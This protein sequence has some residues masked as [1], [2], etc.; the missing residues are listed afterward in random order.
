MRGRY[1]L[2]LTRRM[3]TFG[4][5]PGRLLF[6]CN[7]CAS[8][9]MEDIKRIALET[10]TC[11]SCLSSLRMRA[12]VHL[13]ST[14]LF[15][16]SLVLRDFPVRRDIR[17]MGLSDWKKYASPLSKKLNYT[18]T[19]YHKQPK[20]DITDIEPAL[21]G[22]L[23]F[24]IASDVFEHVAPPVATSFCN[25]YR[26][27]KPGGVFVFTAPYTLEPDTVEHFADLHR[28]K[29]TSGRTPRLINTTRTGQ[30]QVF[31]NLVFHGGRGSTLEM[32]VFS[33]DGLLR[34]FAR[35]GF[36]DVRVHDEIDFEHG[37]YWWDG[38]SLPITARK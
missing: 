3:V 21:E 14:E 34:E 37:I 15:G 33:K 17:G 24:L 2:A 1:W 9:C 10:P 13:L 5:K 12:I 35:A 20:L 25:A 38:W 8:I 30:E 11:H 27:L 16:A 36:R 19:Y 29:L 22:T 7:V 32:R 26:L 18:N 6:R 4:L 23:D 28:Y 31:D